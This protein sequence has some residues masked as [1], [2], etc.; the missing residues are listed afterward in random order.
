MKAANLSTNFT[1]LNEDTFRVVMKYL[2]W[3]EV[4]RI[5]QVNKQCYFFAGAEL[6]SGIMTANKLLEDEWKI[7][8]TMLPANKMQQNDFQH[9]LSHRFMFLR[10]GIEE[11]FYMYKKYV[12]RGVYPVVRAWV[13][14]NA[15]FNDNI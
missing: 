12:G 10:D 1:S 11:L 13:C 3:K 6:M 2:T 8:K 7:L 4:G 14:V 5:R 9:F 15:I